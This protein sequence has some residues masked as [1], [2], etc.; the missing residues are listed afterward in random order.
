MIAEP[1]PA[2]GVVRVLLDVR[3]MAN[4]PEE[5]QLLRSTLQPFTTDWYSSV[6]K[7]RVRPTTVEDQSA[8]YGQPWEITAGG[9]DVWYDSEAPLDKPVYYTAELIGASQSYVVAHAPV[10]LLSYTFETGIT[11]WSADTGGTLSYN[12]TTPIS[13]KGS[14]RYTSLG[15][16]ATIG[17]RAL[18]VGGVVAGQRYLAEFVMRVSVAVTDLRVAVDFVTAANVFITSTFGT[19]TSAPAGVT[20]VRREVFLAPATAARVDLRVRWAGTPPAGATVDVDSV[21]LVDL[22][23]ATATLTANTVTLASNGGGWLHAPELP[24][25]ALRLDLLPDDDCVVAPVPTGVMFASHSGE[26]RAGSGARFDVVQQRLPSIVT[27]VRKAPTATLTVAALSAVDVAAVHS[28]IDT[29]NVLMLRLP[30]E[31]HI[32]DRYLDVG[33]VTT[34]PLSEDLRVPYRIVDLPYAQAPSPAGPAGGVLGQRFQDLD[35]YATW[36]AF[37]AAQLTT[38]DVMLGSASTKGV[39]AL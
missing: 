39:G 37:D 18:R 4:L 31:F 35:R 32:S 6:E 7:V 24:A 36:T 13:G 14:L 10:T 30:P 29:G 17:T 34:V 16:T 20:V 23:D 5:T 21:R 8:Q 19:I 25:G 1:L 9:L 27:G 12:T 3:D 11:G 26:A 28:E 15:T 22:G 33:D 38:L 2:L